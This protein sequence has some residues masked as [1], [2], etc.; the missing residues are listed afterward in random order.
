[1]RVRPRRPARRHPGPQGGARGGRR[2]PRPGRRGDPRRQRPAL[3][4]QR[5]ALGSARRPPHRERPALPVP[6]G[7]YGEQDHLRR[8]RDERRRHG[9]HQSPLRLQPDADRSEDR[10][11]RHAGHRL[12]R[13]RTRPGDGGG[14]R[15]RRTAHRRAG[16]TRAGRA[17]PGRGPLRT[18]PGPPGR[19]GHLQPRLGGAGRR[20][21]HPPAAGSPRRP[22]RGRRP[23][24]RRGHVDHPAR[25]RRAED[26][27]L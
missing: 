7:R 1:V 5:H 22:R 25:S 17:A 11:R 10:R 9:L 24:G 16:G 23:A 12:H 26:R 27:R 13:L 6:A 20:L 4:R 15:L 3:V 19:P 21:G 2:A 14:P 18:L 8:P